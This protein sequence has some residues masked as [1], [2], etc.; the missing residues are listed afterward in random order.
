VVVVATLV[1]VLIS[2]VFGGKWSPGARI[3]LAVVGTGNERRREPTVSAGIINDVR[4]KPVTTISVPSPLDVE[5]HRS[6]RAG[7][8]AL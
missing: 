3:F 5:H 4:G 6:Q 1:G 2:G 8:V 7:D